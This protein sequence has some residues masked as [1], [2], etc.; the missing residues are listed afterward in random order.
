MQTRTLAEAHEFLDKFW[1]NKCVG[2]QFVN[3]SPAGNLDVWV[4]Q[5]LKMREL[6]EPTQAAISTLVKRQECIRMEIVCSKDGIPDR[7]K[8]TRRL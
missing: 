7:I 5:V 4:D 8:V 6:D 3:R 1:E 2:V